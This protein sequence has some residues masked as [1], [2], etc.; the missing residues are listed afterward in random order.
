MFGKNTIMKPVYDSR[1]ALDVHSVFYTIQGEG[2][3][4]GRPAVFV[5]LHGCSLACSWC[6]TEFEKEKHYLLPEDLLAQVRSTLSKFT[7]NPLVVITGGEP[8]RQRLAPFLYLL[9][10]QGYESQIETAGI[11][12]DPELLEVL[13]MKRGCSVVVS[14][15]LSLVQAEL[16]QEA[17]AFKYII[18]A[19]ERYDDIDGLPTYAVSQRGVAPTAKLFRPTAIYTN[20]GLIYVQPM[21]PPNDARLTSVGDYEA[22]ARANT[23]RCIYLAKE[24]GYRLSLQQHKLLNLP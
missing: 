7:P 15:K 5:R 20:P 18:D 17:I 4:A 8:M 2:P 3:H 12:W 9:W 10:E 22:K 24:H 6:D 16:E 23:D 1:G 19:S 11:H 21:D 13:R 14:P